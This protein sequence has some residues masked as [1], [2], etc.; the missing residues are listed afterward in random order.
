MSV[1]VPLEYGGSGQ[2]FFSSIL[3]IEEMSKIDPSVGLLLDL[4]NTLHNRLFLNY[5]TEEQKQYYLPRLA[6][7]LVLLFYFIF[8]RIINENLFLSILGW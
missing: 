7:D 5:G 3:V 1:D 6:K 2:T 4:Q 8:N